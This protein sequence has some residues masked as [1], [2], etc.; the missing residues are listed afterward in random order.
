MAGEV[1]GSASI[2]IEADLRD[3]D[4]NLVRDL[5]RTAREAGD[6][7]ETVLVSSIRDAAETSSDI[8][9]DQLSRAIHTVDTSLPEVQ[10][11]DVDSSL[12]TSSV[13]DSLAVA[14]TAISIEDVESELVTSSIEDSISAADKLVEV[15]ADASQL[16]IEIDSVAQEAAQN[17]SETI[18][19]GL[20]SVDPSALEGLSGALEE[21]GGQ[22][23]GLA[24]RLSVLGVATT[25]ATGGTENVGKAIAALGGGTT[26]AATA[27]VIGIGKGLNNMAKE[28]EQAFLATQRFNR[29]FGDMASSIDH[30]DIAGLNISLSQLAI[31]L[32]ADDDAIRQAASN[33]GQLAQTA[34]ATETE[35]A[36]FVET[37]IVLAAQIS[38]TNPTLG[39]MESILPRLSLALAGNARAGR[40]L[41]ISFTSTQ[42]TAE[43]LAVETG[44]TADQLTFYDKAAAGARLR[45]KQLGDT[46]AS[47][48][49][50]AFKESTFQLKSAN[51]AL[52]EAKETLGEK[53]RVPLNFLKADFAESRTAVVKFASAV[54]ESIDAITKEGVFGGL[55]SS[56]REA[57]KEVKKIAEVDLK[58]IITSFAELQIA[59]AKTPEILTAT[60]KALIAFVNTAVAKL[61]DISQAFNAATSS[62]NSSL[63]SLI[64]KLPTASSVFG[65]FGDEVPKSISKITEALNEQVKDQEAFFANIQK[66]IAKG[67]TDV[68][69]QYLAMGPVEGAALAEVTAHSSK[70]RVKALETATDQAIAANK[71]GQEKFTESAK[72]ALVE[73][74][75]LLLEQQVR[76]QEAWTTNLQAII[77]K[78]G[79]AVA[80]QLIDQG[81][82]QGA[83]LAAATASASQTQ[84]TA[85][86]ASSLN[87]LIKTE[88]SA[89]KLGELSR[90]VYA[91]VGA[92][93][94]QGIAGGITANRYLIQTA[95][96]RAMGLGLIV[97]AAAIERGSPSKLFAR[98]IGRPIAEGIAMGIDSSSSKVEDSLKGIMGMGSSSFDRK[99]DVSSSFSGGVISG[100]SPAPVASGAGVT[101]G[102]V[103][104]HGTNQDPTTI[105]FSVG[106]EIARRASR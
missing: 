52:D 24:N 7:M 19:Q 17:L 29:T 86:E 84:V 34:G 50:K 55:G 27:F 72:A 25:A 90:Q 98:E 106:T 23:D 82:A 101:I 70:S 61:P 88:Q 26:V 67:G 57:T 91:P 41:G 39:S 60:D 79:L 74:A 56:A 73:S 58:P 54:I 85:L 104:V 33:L 75:R 100:G 71:A 15:E 102:E 40:A 30:I 63:D 78:G 89:I 64:G 22:T 81:P 20:D 76:D 32:G 99:F 93:V 95:L 5:E 80:R 16:A 45:T 36:E 8:L 14:D 38:A 2:E 94:A 18:Q 96:K 48:L 83:A 65:S 66:I 49:S 69:N 6:G 68:A 51:Q 46:I 92:S 10:I 12:L 28:A 11:T 105:A 47:D 43:A 31:N 44:K 13:E 103:H 97:T 9:Q 35:T 1:V 87:A 4:R 3:I 59:A 37:L 42:I 53:F 62:S 77:D 21:A